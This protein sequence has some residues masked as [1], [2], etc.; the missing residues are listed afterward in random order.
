MPTLLWLQVKAEGRELSAGTRKTVEHLMRFAQQFAPDELTVTEHYYPKEYLDEDHVVED[1]VVLLPTNP[2][3]C[4]VTF[5]C[6]PERTGFQVWRRDRLTAAASLKRPSRFSVE[7]HCIDAGPEELSIE[8]VMM[9]CDAVSKGNI[10]TSIGSIAGRLVA[11]DI[12]VRVPEPFPWDMNCGF[13]GEMW[14]VFAMRRLKR[15][16]IRRF[17]TQPWRR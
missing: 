12:E 1:A 6:C 5:L 8:Q 4:D 17:E 2:R 10:D 11:M 7:K 14:F 13:S 3:A 16:E 9:I 15:G